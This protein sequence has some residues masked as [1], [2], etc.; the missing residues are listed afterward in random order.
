M[1]KQSL[2]NFLT[3]L[4]NDLTS[5]SQD[6]R[7][8][9]GNK[10][11]TVVHIKASTIT[12]VIERAVTKATNVQGNGEILVKDLG[13]SYTAILNKLMSTLRTNY[14]ALQAKSPESI[15]FKK[16]S[17]SGNEIKVLLIKVEGSKRDNFTT[18]QDYYKDALQEFYDDF[19]A[20]LGK[21]LTRA[22]TSN[23][24][25]KVEQTKQG[26]VF[27]LEHL[28][29]RSNI[30]G[31]INDKIHDALQ[32]YDGNSKD[33]TDA[34]KSLGLKTYLNIEKNAK[35][36]EVKV[37]IGSQ[38]RNVEESSSEQAIKKNLRKALKKALKKLKSPLYELQGSDSIKT[39][40]RKQVI[41][42]T[43]KPFKKVQD[44]NIKVTSSNTK[45]KKEAG[46]VRKDVSGKVAAGLLAKRKLKKRSVAARTAKANSSAAQP[47]QLIGL[48]NNALP[49]TVQKN[50]TSPALVN[51]TGRFAQSV[52]VTDI[53]QTPKGFPSIGYTYQRNPYQVFEDGAGS[54]PWANGERDPR[55]LI[56]GSIREI[57]AQFAIGR[58]YTRR[59]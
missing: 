50:M 17:R 35:T 36:G 29:G 53:V 26:Q 43:I 42:A 10:L 51:R 16:G 20:L 49:K 25:G 12:Y 24:S 55:Q 48:I 39:A 5:S 54:A 4:D 46:S 7:T 30:Q 3:K 44:K 59:V 11:T 41:E 34:V 23:K 32:S 19:A 1:S 40:K 18:A 27:N 22:S 28:K 21:Y 56:D 58:F 52:R 33:L 13:S 15:K 2:I 37:F 45:I 6:W 31:F 14:K 38:G 8:K 47:L 57:A 9:T